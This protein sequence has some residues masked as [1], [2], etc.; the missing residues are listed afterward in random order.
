LMRHRRPGARAYV[1]ANP[2]LG[3][4]QRQP[5]MGTSALQGARTFHA[6]R[7]RT[8]SWPRLT[9]TDVPDERPIMNCKRHANVSITLGIYSH[10]S[11][12]L[13]DEAAARVVSRIFGTDGL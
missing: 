4:V 2:D 5:S 12:T 1:E 13:H 8:I 9:A 11:A 7:S 6:V 10:V 3:E